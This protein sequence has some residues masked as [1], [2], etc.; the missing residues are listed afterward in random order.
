MNS[1]K[2]QARAA[3][4][5]VVGNAAD[6]LELTA[7]ERSLV[8]LRLAVSRAMLF[9]R[10]RSNLTQQ[11]MARKLNTSQSR[12]AKME[13]ASSD[14]SLDALFTGLFALGGSIKDLTAR[15]ASTSVLP[16][17]TRQAKFRVKAAVKT[18]AA[19]RGSVPVV[20]GVKKRD[21]VTQKG[22]S[23]PSVHTGKL[24]PKK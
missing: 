20:T 7:E 24:V 21:K 19:S 4:G 13:S 1:R 6:F 22:S 3:A 23:T 5:W 8:E 11:A 2:K 12:V 15:H 10:K 9:R 16:P 18:K 17:S 14:V